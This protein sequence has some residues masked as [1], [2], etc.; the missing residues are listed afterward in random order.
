MMT[1]MSLSLWTETASWM[2]SS[3]RWE[4]AHQSLPIHWQA[5]GDHISTRSQAL[6]L[7]T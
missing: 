3:N 4:P 5:L 1:M 2:S 6:H 7:H